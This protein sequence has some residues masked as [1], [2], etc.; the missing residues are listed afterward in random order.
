[1]CDPS[2][3]LSGLTDPTAAG[4][5]GSD[6]ITGGA[7]SGPD[8]SGSATGAAT[9]AMAGATT[10][11][12]DMNIGGGP[13]NV[14]AGSPMA[15]PG[16]VSPTPAGEVSPIV[17]AN[18]PEAGG[19]GT[20]LGQGVAT[21]ASQKPKGGLASNLGSLAGLG[22][23]G[24][25]AA[26]ALMGGQVGTQPYGGTSGILATQELVQGQNLMSY[27]SSGKLPPGI[28]NHFDAAFGSQAAK[29]KSD[30]AARGQSGSSAEASD[31]NALQTS[32]AG[33]QS[34]V[35]RQLYQMGVTEEQ[36][37]MKSLE[38]IQKD[39][40][41]EQQQAQS[42]L[43]GAVEKF[44]GALGSAGASQG[45]GSLFSALGPLLAA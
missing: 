43:S 4:A 35:A 12:Q 19:A 8:L 30:Y 6:A 36:N 15:L 20:A 9:D 23:T 2:T 44:A 28:E 34:Q 7:V 31:L 25:L 1:M 11:L 40:N 39:Q 14:A 42:G 32:R 22:L 16:S 33:L 27:L 45:L 41:A 24:G 17:A 5:I 13:P 38:Q 10:Q 29:I 26:K 18:T 37:A 3:A 21:P